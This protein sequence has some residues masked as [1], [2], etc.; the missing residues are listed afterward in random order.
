[1]AVAAAFPQV[2]RLATVVSEC[3]ADSLPRQSGVRAI[4]VAP[5][6]TTGLRATRPPHPLVA[7]P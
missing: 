6:A 1:M 4:A 7:A 5:C 3:V 2:R